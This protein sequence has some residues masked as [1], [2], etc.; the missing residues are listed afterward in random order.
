MLFTKKLLYSS[1]S[2]LNKSTQARSEISKEAT[3]DIFLS[4]SYDD[5]DYI[6]KL[7][8]ILKT[9]GYSVYVDWIVENEIDRKNVSTMTAKILKERM[10]NCK[11]LLYATSTSASNSKWMP[12]ELGYFDG[13]KKGKVAIIPIMENESGTFTGQEYLGLYPYLDS[14]SDILWI[15]KD[16]GIFDKFADWINA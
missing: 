10:K 9:Y 3:F 16:F 5:R 4:H 12:W 7:F 8:L 1:S 2:Y 11:C 14:V 6:L 15:N 13:L